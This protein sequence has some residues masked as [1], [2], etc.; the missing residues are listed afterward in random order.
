VDL[1]PTSRMPAQGRRPE[2]ERL[3]L[4][5]IP[6]SPLNPLRSSRFLAWSPSL[7]SRDRRE[8]ISLLSDV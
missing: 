2:Q 3:V 5:Q 8:S 6:A 7:R 1:S 4:V